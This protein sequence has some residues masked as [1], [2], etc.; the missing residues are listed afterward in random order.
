[1][2]EFGISNKGFNRKRLDTILE[3]LNS[4]VKSIFGT[5]FNISPESPDGQIN[6]V[7][8]ES[9]ANLWEIAEESYNAFNPSAVTGVTQDNLYQLNGLTRLEARSSFALLTLSGTQSTTIPEGSLVS[10]SDTN[11][12]FSIQSEVVIPVGGSISVI[13]NAVE[14]GAI[15]ALAGTLT[16]IDTP[17]SGW[18]SVTNV[19][20]AIKGTEEETDVEFRA[21]RARSVAR[22]AQALVDAIFSE[23]RSVSGVTQATVLENDTNVNPDANGLPDHSIHVIA[24][25]GEDEDIANAIFIKKTLGVTP[26]GTTT[27]VVNDNQGIEHNISFSRPNKIDIYVEVNLTTFSTYPSEGDAQ[28]K[29]AIVDYAQ[30]NLI[31]GRGFF[32]GDKVI[33][34]EIYTPINTISGH[35]VDSMFIKTSSPADQTSDISI[36]VSE[37]SNFTISNITVNS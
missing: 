22:D 33:H 36:S 24:V 35:T 12:Q 13:A 25:G 2:S 9:N 23:V 16:N 28:I 34:S 6:G 31:E 19:S 7:I 37:V 29:Q 5:N 15:S 3:D 8:S 27:V 14:T 4:E 10:T 32:L 21:R 30:G 18:D 26:F 1:M 11:V 17:L 20:D